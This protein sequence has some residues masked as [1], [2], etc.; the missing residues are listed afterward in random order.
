MRST[1][2]VSRGKDSL[3]LS[4]P[5]IFPQGRSTTRAMRSICRRPGRSPWCR[6]PVKK[7]RRRSGS[8][9]SCCRTLL[10]R[11]W[12]ETSIGSRPNLMS[13]T[14]RTTS[15]SLHRPKSLPISRPSTISPRSSSRC[16]RLAMDRK[17][18]CSSAIPPTLWPSL[19]SFVWSTKMAT[20]SCRS[21]GTTTTFRFCPAKAVS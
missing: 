14:T 17:S 1:I 8:S 19:S 2:P 10:A 12:P 13:S 6:L 15:G 18:R 21:C 9:I 5:S 20:R 4:G 3:P 11:R 7:R 16:Q